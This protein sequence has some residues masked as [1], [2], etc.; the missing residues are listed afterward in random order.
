MI[1]NDTCLY[2]NMRTDTI[3]I[4]SPQ[5]RYSS[6]PSMHLAIEPQRS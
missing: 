4:K 5:E 2:T 6:D 3:D 1:E